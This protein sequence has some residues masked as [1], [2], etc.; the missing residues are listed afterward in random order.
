LSDHGQI[1]SERLSFELERQVRHSNIP[2]IKDPQKVDRHLLENGD[3]N[4]LMPNSISE[5]NNKSD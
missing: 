2:V 1:K 4:C 3:D 5:L